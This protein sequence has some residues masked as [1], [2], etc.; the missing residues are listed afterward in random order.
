MRGR[1]PAGPE[2]VEQ[3]HGSPQARLRL[4]VVLETLAGRRRVQQ[5][6]QLLGIG[7]VR[8]HALRQAVLEAALAALEPRPLGRPPRDAAAQPEQAEALLGQVDALTVE[9]EAAQLREEV[10]LLLTN[11][12]AAPEKKTTR[13]ASRP[14]PSR[15]RK[16]PTS[17]G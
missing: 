4:R 6:C 16:R 11:R 10:A 8:F 1:R 3:L 2:I 17:S 12:E 14:R 15:P 5:A 9:L 13:A 7:T